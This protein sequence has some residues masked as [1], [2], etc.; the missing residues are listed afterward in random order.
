VNQNH[1]HHPTPPNPK[2]WMKN[3]GFFILDQACAVIQQPDFLAPQ[4]VPGLKYS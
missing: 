4:A 2:I 3:G 1:H